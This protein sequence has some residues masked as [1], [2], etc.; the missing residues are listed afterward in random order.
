MDTYKK[1]EF[2]VCF[3][4]NTLEREHMHQAVEMLYVMGGLIRLRVFEKIFELRKD[5]VI[6]INSNH[7][8][9]WTE[10]ESSHVCIIHFDYSML[11][12]FM[13]KKIIFFY[14]NSS[15]EKS[16][17][18]EGIRSIM[19]DFFSECAVNMDGMTFQKKGLLYRLLHYLVSYFMTNMDAVSSKEGN[20]RIEGMLQYINANY[21]RTIPLQEISEAMHMAPTSFSRFFKK[22]V[23]MTYVEYINNIRLH[24]A[25]E[26]ILY[27]VRPVSWIAHTHGF[28]NAS[29][30]CR[31]FK[32]TYGI[33]PLAFRRQ[34]SGKRKE[35]AADE[36]DRIF[37]KKY[38][39]KNENGM[40]K[41]WKTQCVSVSADVLAREE[42]NNP[43]QK[44]LCLGTACGLQ[45][46]QLREQIIKAREEIRFIYGRI[47]GLFASEMC[48]RH[49]HVSYISS[50]YFIDMVLDFLISQRIKPVISLDNKPQS[51]V[52]N[53]NSF[54][55][56][57]KSEQIFVDLTECIGVLDD[58][59]R[60]IVHRYGMSEV[61]TWKFECWYDEFYENTMGIPGTF[62]D[63]YECICK[64]IKRYIPKA[65][66]GGCGLGVSISEKKYS[67]L[68]KLW[69][70]KKEKPDFVSVYLYPYERLDIPGK[71]KGKRRLNI[72]DFY[73][74]EVAHCKKLMSDVG[75][76][77]I[78]LLITE[79]NMSISWRNFFNDTCGKATL[80]ARLMSELTGIVEFAGYMQLSD[81]FGQYEDTDAF[82]FGGLGLMTASGVRKPAYYAIQFVS[83][84][85]KFLIWKDKNCIITTD[86]CGEYEI[87]CFN[88]K[89]LRYKYYTMDE[90]KL[91]WKDEDDIF[92]NQ[93]LLEF[94]LTL[95]NVPE[96]DWHMK[97]YRV[98][99]WRNS[100][101]N[102]WQFM[103]AE[104]SPDVEDL[105]YLEKTCIPLQRNGVLKSDG[106]KLMM[107]QMLR[108]QELKFIRIYR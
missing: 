77:D 71:L 102:A 22:N 20:L 92:E 44:M 14:C 87:L 10:L 49:G 26:D 105:A 91:S 66:V 9:S 17:R 103:E 97:E 90:D 101:F 78:P 74:N 69:S 16:E 107:Q 72:E 76:E 104:E 5:D 37:L 61:E 94:N 30:F 95:K 81:Y 23:G 51:I 75:W 11:L 27:T 28:T 33:P 8:H 29:A 65:L 18:Y 21:N 98:G 68:L 84:L 41:S 108:S 7:R 50:F 54:V 82:L 45:N 19:E 106:K 38:L 58:F 63:I 85:G 88:A 79:W 39:S 93:D 57:K 56:E 35:N 2:E 86:G 83:R 53:I 3:K 36:K 15:M 62:P 43:W 64:E 42:W 67:E 60:H 1:Q 96:G 55:C 34:M 46:S 80:M 13:E 70:L 24:F 99:S 25:L 100:V 59:L 4:N 73:K 32:E 12:E 47:T 48:F 89:A 40:W 31:I 6:V 52:K